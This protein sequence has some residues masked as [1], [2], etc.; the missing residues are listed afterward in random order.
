MLINS[1]VVEN[2]ERKNA[3][4][5]TRQ[6]KLAN[7][8]LCDQDNTEFRNNKVPLFYCVAFGEK[9]AIPRPRSVRIIQ[10]K[11]RAKTIFVWR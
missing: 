9:K 3:R 10:K 4:V 6:W 7:N 11:K 5:I 2:E 8:I 1:L